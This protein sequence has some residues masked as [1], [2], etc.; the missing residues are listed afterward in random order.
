[1][2]KRVVIE[3]YRSCLHTSIDLHPNLSVLIGPNGS[4]KTNILQAIMFLNKMAREPEQHFS[5][6]GGISVMSRLKATFEYGRTRARLNASVNAYAD[7][8]NNDV[9]VGSRQKW[10]LNG[11]NHRHASFQAPLSLIGRIGT[12]SMYRSMFGIG[13]RDYY[14]YARRQL[15]LKSGFSTSDKWVVH[16]LRSIANYCAGMRYYGA[17]QFTNPGTCPASFEI[18]REG[19][20]L[21]LS[22]S[23]GHVKILYNMYSAFKAKNPGFDQ[24]MEIVGPKG[25]RL[26]DA[27]SFRRVQTASVEHSVRVGGKVEVRKRH[28][29]LV[30]PQFR[31]GKQMLSPNQLSEGTF[32]TLSLLFHVITESSS[33]LLIEEPEVCVHH[34]LLSSVLELIKSFS[35]RKQMILSTHSDYVLD[36]VSPDNVFRVTLDADRGTVARHIRKTM[37]AKEYSALREYL[38]QEG[39]LGEFWREGGLGDRP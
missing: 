23:R 8:S 29:L 18:D 10:E 16:S 26:I 38:E 33:A 28:K 37:N 22:R 19:N 13:S 32:K 1:M 21:G 4:G 17:A 14:Q 5:R 2:L 15:G 24:F 3:N 35:R 31:I 36:H 11:Q 39:N 6:G 27:L 12:S 9:M 20:R 34:G 7:E 25:L 30:I